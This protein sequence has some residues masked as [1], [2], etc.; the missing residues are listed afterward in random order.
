MDSF[1]AVLY[2]KTNN[3]TDEH[4]SVALLTAGSEGPR[5][6]LSDKRLKLLNDV[7]HRNTFLSIRR[8]LKSFQQQVDK[9][10]NA[11]KDLLLFDPTYSEQELNRVSKLSKKTIRYSL[12]VSVN[13]WMDEDTHQ[14]LIQQLLG[15]KPV[16][17]KTVKKSFYHRWK[18][19]C[20]GNRYIDF[21]RNILS[22]KVKRKTETPVRLDLYSK[23]KKIIVKG[24]DFDTSPKNVRERLA[25][26]LLL[27]DEFTDFKFFCVYPTPRKK[28]GRL[29]LSDAK[30]RL[31]LKIEFMTFVEFDAHH[32]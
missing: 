2:I 23:D 15:E 4:L 1:Y 29:V 12:P 6:Y 16:K 31:S 14:Q 10:R 19:H 20:N 17:V 21:R 32:F 8:H 7:L 27:C 25:D 9:Y 30:E 13:A 22:N 18:A 28:A 3:L 11:N 5:V 24:L 26:M